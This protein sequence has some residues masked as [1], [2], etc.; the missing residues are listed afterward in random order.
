MISPA[1]KKRLKMDVATAPRIYGL[2]KTHKDGYPLRP[3]CS[4]ID[5]PSSNLCKYI[6]NLLKI[7]TQDSKYNIKDSL[8]F[9]NKIKNLT[10]KEDEKL[11]S[12]DVVSLF[13]SVPVDLALKIIESRWQE[14]EGHTRLTKNIFMK[15][16]K[17]CIVENRYF[18][19]EDKT[20]KQKR[21]LPMGSSAS[22]IVAD[23]VMEHLLDNC[24]ENL[25]TKPK[26]LTKYVDDIFAVVR[27]GA[28]HEI[29]T[30]LNGFHNSIKFTVEIEKNGRIPYLDTLVIRK[31]NYKLG[32]DWYQKPTA[33]GRIMNYFSQH[34]K[35][36]VI[37]TAKNLIN[38]VL[39]ISDKEYH[40]KNKSIIRDILHNNN[41]PKYLINDLISQF[42]PEGKKQNENKNEETIYKSLVYVNKLSERIT[43]SE[44]FDKGQ[45]TLAHKSNNTLK[46]LFSNMKTK[47]PTM[48]KHN[49]IY[50]IPCGGNNKEKCEKVYVG[51]SKNKLK[52]RISGHKSDIKL[53]TNSNTTKTALAGHCARNN[54][55]PNFDDVRILE[56]ENNYSKRF[57]LETLHINN[58]PASK[59]M[60]FKVDT[61]N[62]AHC[63]RHL[64]RKRKQQIHGSDHRAIVK[65]TQC[66]TDS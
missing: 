36:I 11:V 25:T 46:K 9:K 22:P 54:H 34:P 16:L 60:N 49:T 53:R 52:T 4:S 20:Y 15:I 7:L 38:R 2:P 5:S 37:N 42:K 24:M 8:Q 14:L 64:L 30:T 6:G 43:N 59:R 47:I 10:I 13:P 1:E 63:Y 17:F 40:S 44:I 12:F 35:R 58:V 50:E 23:I 21:G 51:T 57:T 45:Y 26:I 3:I 61:E 62:I 66:N 55:T 19:Y 32:L 27:E 39:N 48:E 31:E 28:I 41:F 33:S 65:T 56:R 29:L 18:T